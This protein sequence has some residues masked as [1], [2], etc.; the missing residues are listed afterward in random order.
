MK[1]TI[2]ERLHPFSHENGTQFILPKSSLAVVIFPTRLQFTDLENRSPPFFVDFFLA[3]PVK[4]FTAELDL[5][6]GLIRVYGRARDGFLR[7]LV[8]AEKDGVWLTME[9]IPNGKMEC[10]H[11]F[12]QQTFH[13][14]KED[15]LLLP[16]NL[17]NS[18]IIAVEERLSLGMHKAQEWKSICSRLDFKEI[19]PL[20]QRLCAWTPI[21]AL[22]SR[23]GNYLLLEECRRQIE[24]REKESV[25]AA[26]ENFFLS[27]FQGILVPRLNDSEYQGILPATAFSKSNISPLPLLT[28]GGKLIRSLF[29]LE[30]QGEIAILPCLPAQ[31]HCGRITGVKTSQGSIVDF[32]WTKKSLRRLRLSSSKGGDVRLKLPKGI[33][34][35]R[36]KVGRKTLKAPSIDSDGKMTVVLKAH[37]VV[38]LDRFYR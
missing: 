15:K 23:E 4:E 11:S 34:S 3:G 1:I 7:Y 30:N 14:T 17:E 31:F 18:G 26:F 13:L 29:F 38:H 9:K 2:A 35:C 19:F 10:Q 37:E 22:S 27:A 6:L 25:L 5:E 20:W 28:E 21:K 16:Q 12:A 32:E 36:I 24:S 33:A 8:Q